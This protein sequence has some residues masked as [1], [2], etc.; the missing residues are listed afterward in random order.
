M[1]FMKKLLDLLNMDNW[2]SRNNSLDD[3]DLPPSAPITHSLP[4]A[5]SRLTSIVN[6]WRKHPQIYTN[7]FHI[8]K[9]E[10]YLLYGKTLLLNVYTKAHSLLEKFPVYFYS[11]CHIS[12]PLKLQSALLIDGYLEPASA[13]LALA[14]YTIPEL[15]FIAESIGCTKTGK[16]AE[17]V[18]RVYHALDKEARDT[19]VLQSGL[20]MLS[21]K[22]RLFMD[23]N[24]DYIELHRHWEYNICLSEYNQNRSSENEQ[25]NFYTIAYTILLKK[26][27][28]KLSMHQYYRIVFD[29]LNL[30]DIAISESKYDLAIKYCLQAF[31]LK[32][33]CT[34]N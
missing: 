12:D 23:K 34:H 15:K 1:T 21:S 6:F 18:N 9:P 25:H 28:R 7:D 11:E 22:G 20:Y 17:L 4:E 3:N 2:N 26:A 19:I 33:C 16:K 13:H 8:A 31:Y 30:Y 5:T 29:Y 10:E 24:S 14:S 27:S 32:T